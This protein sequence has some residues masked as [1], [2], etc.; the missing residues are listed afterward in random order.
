[1]SLSSQSRSRTRPAGGFACRCLVLAG[2]LCWPIAY[3]QA[4]EDT[5]PQA[6]F[7]VGLQ[8]LLD[9]DYAAAAKVFEALFAETQSERVRLEWA[10]AAYLQQ[11]YEKAESLF[12]AVLATGPPLS[13]REKIEVFLEDIRLAQGS[14]DY[15]FSLVRDSNPVATT[16]VRSFNLF[17][18]P[19]EYT[20]QVGTKTA[21]GID[22]RLSGTKGL[23]ESRRWIGS[24]G[25][26][27]THF[28]D[29]TINRTG[30]D[31]HL[32]FRMFFEPRVEVKLSHERANRGT[33]PLY[34]FSS[35]N[36]RHVIETSARWRWSNELRY[37][38][39]AY[40]LSTYQNSTLSSYR[41][42]GDWALSPTAAI[43]FE[44]VWDTGR[45][46]EHPYSFM[47]NS[48]GLTGAH[49]VEAVATRVTLKWLAT[50]RRHAEADPFFGI[51][52]VDLQQNFIL[53]FEPTALRIAG[54]TPVVELR[55][56]KNTS[57]LPLSSYDRTVGSVILKRGF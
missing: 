52:R 13:V 8:F 57:T 24:V 5:Q 14:V 28:G 41:L 30:L 34:R 12:K 44:L 42:S 33:N 6:R 46:A 29:P 17:G 56:E 50:N 15:S 32:I 18:L 22:Y 25:L 55:R 51:H 9:R 54:L 37:G 21:W 20:P 35:L 31:A 47:S 27:G 7:N 10:R 19:F 48:Y 11:D 40:P 38:V 16:R 49:F 1:M 53:T 43:G 26:V 4:A 2:L 3:V 39:I 45:A 23:D 36:F